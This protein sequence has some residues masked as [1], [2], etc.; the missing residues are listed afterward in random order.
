MERMTVEEA[1]EVA[2]RTAKRKRPFALPADAVLGCFCKSKRCHGDVIVKL[3]HE[4]HPEV[5]T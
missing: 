5:E 4:M 2:K 3:W 1:R